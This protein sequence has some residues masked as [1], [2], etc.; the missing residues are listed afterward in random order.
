MKTS[1]QI[2][3]EMKNSLISAY[4]DLHDRGVTPSLEWRSEADARLADNIE[5]AYMAFAGSTTDHS[6]VGRAMERRYPI[7]A[8]VKTASKKK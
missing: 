5:L 6:S 7:S 2:R 3:N 4:R 8:S 1:S